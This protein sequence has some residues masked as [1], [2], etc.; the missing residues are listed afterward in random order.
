MRVYVET[1]IIADWLLVKTIKTKSRR[2]VRPRVY[3][4]FRL[5]ELIL[6]GRFPDSEFVTSFWAILEGVGVLK[7]SRIQFNMLTQNINLGYYNDFK[8]KKGFK[9]ETYQINEI[10]SKIKLLSKSSE[11]K[12]QTISELPIEFDRTF[13]FLTVGLDPPDAIHATIAIGE[14]CKLFVTRDTDFLSRTETLKRYLDVVN[15]DTALQ[16]LLATRQ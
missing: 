16:R 15:P 13:R 12:L 1:S 7:R 9:L 14:K 11:R 2:K 3:K 5:M 10:A 4:S 8:D 6:K